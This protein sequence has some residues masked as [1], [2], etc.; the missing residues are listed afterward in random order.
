MILYLQKDKMSY[1]QAIYNFVNQQIMFIPSFNGVQ[2]EIREDDYT[3]L[4]YASSINSGDATRLFYQ[5]KN[6]INL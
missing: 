3:W 1:K 5:I 2:F 6:L 4:D